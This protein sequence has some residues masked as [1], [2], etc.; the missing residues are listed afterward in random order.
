M[1]EPIHHFGTIIT[2]KCVPTHEN[3]ISRRSWISQRCYTIN[4]LH[5]YVICIKNQKPPFVM[6]TSSTY[7]EL[8]AYWIWAK[9]VKHFW[10]EK[11]LNFC[12]GLECSSQE[13]IQM[14]VH[15]AIAALGQTTYEGSHAISKVMGSII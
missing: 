10:L 9:T 3:L 1:D 13:P 6:Q 11:W 8:W 15:N 2:E 14:L 12:R 7:V 4:T 5:V